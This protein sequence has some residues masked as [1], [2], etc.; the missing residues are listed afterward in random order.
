MTTST[1]RPE[2]WAAA[3]LLTLLLHAAVIVVMQFTRPLT[4]S[5]TA[6]AAPAPVEF[7]FAPPAAEASTSEDPTFFSELPADRADERPERP[8]FL[9]SVDSRARD[10]VPGGE[11]NLPRLEGVSEAP[12]IR[13][14]P[15]A[16]VPQEAPRIEEEADAQERPIEE[17]P[18]DPATADAQAFEDAG[19]P[20][21]SL[22]LQ[23]ERSPL[24]A[25][26]DGGPARP[27]SP[28]RTPELRELARP[29]TPPR[30]Q[31]ASDFFQA[32]MQRPGG[33][34]ALTGS[35][36][37]N[38]VEWEYAPWLQ[39]FSRRLQRSWLAP[40]AYYMGIIQGSTEMELEVAKDGSLQRLVVRD[41]EGHDSLRQTSVAVLEALAPYRPLPQ[42]F[43][44]KSLVL[45]ITLVY[46]PL[47][48]RG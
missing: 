37:L 27:E 41:A 12:H 7:V 48:G 9:S 35:V 28:P 1:T 31:G 19:A 40:V 24:D 36:S 22:P 44:E 3:I 2:I 4:P 15:A 47:R 16:D 10:R 26:P 43:P 20:M 30:P 21:A 6:S 18:P 23:S 46:P 38:T 14:D 32:E 39:E 17:A 42:D 8:D 11:E 13:F 29:T 33:N 25:R 5:A 34:A 45:R